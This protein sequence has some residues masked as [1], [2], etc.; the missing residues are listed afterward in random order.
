MLVLPYCCIGLCLLPR[1]GVITL[2]TTE[3]VTGSAVNVPTAWTGASRSGNLRSA[4][5]GGAPADGP[6]DK[7]RQAVDPDGKAVKGATMTATVGVG[8]RCGVAQTPREVT[9]LSFTS[10]D[11]PL[12]QS[13]LLQGS[14]RLFALRSVH[15]WE[16]VKLP[17][18]DATQRWAT[19][20]VTT[21]C[22]ANPATNRRGR[23]SRSESTLSPIVS[24]HAPSVTIG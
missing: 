16:R 1:V 7:A 13:V 5:T 3:K 18:C 21:V 24:G 9:E 22:L 14:D 20:Q 15:E 6:L 17:K 12:R 8:N 23:M 10:P 19:Q 11:A 4:L 2:S